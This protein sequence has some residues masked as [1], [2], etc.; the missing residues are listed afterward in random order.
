[1]PIN[2]LMVDAYPRLTHTE[3]VTGLTAS[4]VLVG[5]LIGNAWAQQYGHAFTA[6]GSVP[7]SPTRPSLAGPA[8]SEA[9]L[10]APAPAGGRAQL[11]GDAQPRHSPG[12][13]DLAGNPFKRDEREFHSGTRPRRF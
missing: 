12:I 7:T 9:N 11:L 5:R 10:P 6:R 13:T 3:S 2:S 8:S 1:M 4:S